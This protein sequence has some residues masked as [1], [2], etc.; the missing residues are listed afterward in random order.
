MTDHLAKLPVVEVAQWYRRLAGH[1]Q[2]LNTDA[3]T[4]NSPCVDHP[5]APDMLIKWL[6]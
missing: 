5:L 3:C 4:N 6:D 1:I 2:K